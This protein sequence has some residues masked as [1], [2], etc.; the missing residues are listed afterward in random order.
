MSVFS[1]RN[2]FDDFRLEVTHDWRYVRK[3]PAEDFLRGVTATCKK[4]LFSFRAGAELWRAQLGN[5]W[6]NFTADAATPFSRVRPFAPCRM[7]PRDHR[8]PEGRANPKGIPYL[9]LSTTSTAAMSEVRPWIGALVSVAQFKIVREVKIVDCSLALRSNA[10]G[11]SA[12]PTD[13][14]VDEIVWAAIDRAFAQPV[15]HSDD[16]ADYA[17]TQTIAELF[18]N[19]GYDGVGY[20][21]PFGAEGYSVVLFDIK[22]ARQING[23]LYKVESVDF[24]FS[25]NVVDHYTVKDDGTI[26]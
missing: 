12:P 21:S 6:D 2:S 11:K 3:P 17:A 18:R 16:V 13:T 1:S 22:S 8:A 5:H 4:R 26:L 10:E 7:K 25:D 24:K 23:L 20:K 15:T 14:E 19:E 9:Y